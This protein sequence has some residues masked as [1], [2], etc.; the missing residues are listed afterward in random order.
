MI[1]ANATHPVAM[2]GIATEL[3]YV[4]K[5]ILIWKVTASIQ[6]GWGATGAGGLG[7]GGEWGWGRLG[8]GWV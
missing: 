6:T 8:K 7:A 1:N 3:V 4:K 2:T 5:T